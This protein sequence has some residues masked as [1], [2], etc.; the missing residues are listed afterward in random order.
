MTKNGDLVIKLKESQKQL[1][2]EFILQPEK[3]ESY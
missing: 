2:D 3:V 1:C